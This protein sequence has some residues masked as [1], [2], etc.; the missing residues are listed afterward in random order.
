[1]NYTSDLSKVPSTVHYAALEF[2]S[3]YV[4]GDERSRTN[5]GHGYPGHSESVVKYITFA[6]KEEME[7]WVEKKEK[8]S[9]GNPQH[10]YK[11]FEMKP[12]SV[13]LSVSVG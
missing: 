3:I 12:L 1:M 8:P 13:K 10:D 2:S 11:I 4:E 9:F 6:S 5:P 7:K